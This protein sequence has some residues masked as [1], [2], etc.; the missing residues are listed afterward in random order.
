M[1]GNNADREKVVDLTEIHQR[2]QVYIE[3]GISASQAIKQVAKD[4]G[5][6]K[7]EIY[8]FYHSKDIKSDH[9]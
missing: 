1:E 5:M 7:N 8:S 2:I 9:S 4:T 3:G 6:N